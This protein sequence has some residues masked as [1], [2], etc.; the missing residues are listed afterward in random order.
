MIH[1][2]LYTSNINIELQEP[3]NKNVNSD[4]PDWL[5]LLVFVNISVLFLFQVNYYERYQINPIV[6]SITWRGLD[7]YGLII[8]LLP[9]TWYAYDVQVFNTAGL[10]SIGDTYFQR[11]TLNGNS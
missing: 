5:L 2:A 4:I 9:N 10:N 7:P 3:H 6:N 8:G 1:N 11:T